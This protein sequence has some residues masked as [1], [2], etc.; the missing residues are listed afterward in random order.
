MKNIL[1]V[2]LITYNRKKHLERTL[3]SI[4]DQGSPIADL[5]FTIVDNASSDGSADVIKAYAAKYPNIRYIRRNRNIGGNANIAGAF[6]L[7]A[8]KYL[9]VLCDD[10]TYDFSAWPQITKAIEEDYDLILTNKEYLNGRLSGLLRRL[11]FLPSAIFKTSFLDENVM[12]NIFDNIPNWF[13]HLAV[14]VSI[15]NKSGRIFTP[16]ANIVITGMENASS[17]EHRLKKY[18]YLSKRATHTFF[19]VCFFNIM[20]LVE[21]KKAR[22]EAVEHYHDNIESFFWAIMSDYKF[23]TVF[24]GNYSRNIFEPL[25]VFSFTQK[26]RF[27]FAIICL[28]V[29]ALLKY[30]RYYFKKK[31]LLKTK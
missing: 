5:D 31:K 12:A 30:P 3:K 18:P 20:E 25:S 21:N 1:E 27:I 16:S 9:W 22:Y 13:P 29:L 23:N 24:L 28:N 17:F 11:S 19:A 2:I 15:F 14:S 8:K 4:F 10:D 7:A 6:E 26:V